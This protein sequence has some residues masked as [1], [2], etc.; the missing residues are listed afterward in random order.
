M[1]TFWKLVCNHLY[2]AIMGQGYST[3]FKAQ[4][5]P[6]WCKGV[7]DCSPP[8]V[9]KSCPVTCKNSDPEECKFMSCSMAITRSHCPV[10]CS[11]LDEP[12]ECKL[13][14]CLIEEDMQKC[15][16]MCSKIRKGKVFYS[17]NYT[18]IK[19][20][21]KLHLFLPTLYCKICISFNFYLG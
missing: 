18:W 12:E 11:K 20:K 14:N 1:N 2:F 8:E 3:R 10:K 15:R 9:I 7:V 13:A 21:C 16:V 5:E 19:F 6:D 17:V 4:H